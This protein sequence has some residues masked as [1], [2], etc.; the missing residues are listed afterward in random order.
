MEWILII[1]SS[2]YITHYGSFVFLA[3]NVLNPLRKSE[4]PIA[5][6][7]FVKQGLSVAYDVILP[8]TD[9]EVAGLNSMQC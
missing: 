4:E 8:T 2:P 7:G 3:E 1:Y 9:M 6:L 5:L